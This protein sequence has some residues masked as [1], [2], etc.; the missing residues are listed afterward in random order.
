MGV[1]IYYFVGIS[2]FFANNIVWS[3]AIFV[4][5]YTF[6]LDKYQIHINKH[7]FFIELIIETYSIVK[8]DLFFLL[9]GSILLIES[10]TDYINNDV[11]SICNILIIVITLIFKDIN[12]MDV[13]FALTLPITLFIINKIFNGIG[14]G[15]IE[16]LI[17]LC[18]LFN[19]YDL[20]RIVLLSSM[21]NIIYAFFT[22][23]KCFP[24]VPFLTC[25]IFIFWLI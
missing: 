2:L 25:S 12:L 24:F 20:S 19:I 6:I 8:N 10:I 21:L 15:D 3:L 17:S 11:Y 14:L 18:F 13:L 5:I 9:F 7:V 4:L 1:N 22:K 23:K 16:L